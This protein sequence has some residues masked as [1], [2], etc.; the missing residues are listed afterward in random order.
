MMRAWTK[1]ALV[2]LVG[3][4]GVMSVMCVVQLNSLATKIEEIH[5]ELLAIDTGVSKVA[6]SVR[7]REQSPVIAVESNRVLDNNIPG[8]QIEARRE[9]GAPASCE[10]MFQEILN[11]IH[12]LRLSLG[13]S[14]NRN[15]V[16]SNP[17]RFDDLEQLS[18]SW[19]PSDPKSLQLT[20]AV[21]EKLSCSE[22]M[23]KLGEPT[24][25]SKDVW[26]W[27]WND[28]RN[29]KVVKFII[30]HIRNGVPTDVRISCQ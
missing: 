9:S 1:A 14:E 29:P 13:D 27:C 7:M 12:E 17:T 26:E 11:A 22:L 6:D 25:G 21:L 10:Q 30:V 3:V 2:V 20:Q 16:N 8:H 5:G 24:G 28:S 19:I 18:A 4:V 15:S 23:K